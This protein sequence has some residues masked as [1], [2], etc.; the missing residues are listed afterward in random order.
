MKDVLLR[1]A[2]PLDQARGQCYDGCDTMTGSKNGMT[3][4]LK[5]S[6]LHCLLTHCYYHALNLAVGDLVKSVPVMKETLGDAYELT[7][8]IKYSPEC[9]AALKKKRKLKI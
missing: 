3:T 8:L 7:K 2:L 9:E 4:I 1:L 6:E 5:K